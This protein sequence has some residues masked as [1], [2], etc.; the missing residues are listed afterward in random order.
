[1]FLCRISAALERVNVFLQVFCGLGKPPW[2]R[3]F[4]VFNR[5]RF[6][7]AGRL[8]DPRLPLFWIQSLKHASSVYV[9]RLCPDSSWHSFVYDAQNNTLGVLHGQ[10][11]C[12]LQAQV[13]RVVWTR[14]ACEFEER[15]HGGD[16]LFV[17]LMRR[18]K[19]RRFLVQTRV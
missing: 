2:T 5:V 19:V 11:H 6:S 15:S 10:S 16:F 1:M 3:C 8:F 17:F 9:P 7:Q 14:A 12:R 4:I 18:S 13:Q